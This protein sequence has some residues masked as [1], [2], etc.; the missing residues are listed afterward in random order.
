MRDYSKGVAKSVG[1]KVV[2]VTNRGG[3]SR[4]M[5]TFKK[6]NDDGLHKFAKIQ[7]KAGKIPWE[8]AGL[9]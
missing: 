1:I 5:E 2:L 9:P 4:L 6:V 7:I 3:K 8:P